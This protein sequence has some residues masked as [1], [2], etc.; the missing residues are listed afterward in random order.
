MHPTA[1][2]RL[3]STRAELNY[4]RIPCVDGLRGLAI[5]SVLYSHGSFSRGMPHFQWWPF[6]GSPGVSVFFILTGF[7]VTTLLLD[8]REKTGQI[9]IGKFLVRRAYRIWPALYGFLLSLLLLRHLGWASF[10]DRAWIAAATHWFNFYR[11]PNS[12][13]LSHMWSLSLQECFYLIWPPLLWRLRPRQALMFSLAL[14]LGWPLVRLLLD[15]ELAP[16]PAHL[17]LD[18]NGLNT[19]FYGVI[20]A[21]LMRDRAW[22]PWLKKLSAT[23]WGLVLPLAVLYALYSLH[24]IWPREW[25]VVLAPGRNLSVLIILWWCISNEKH[26]VGRLLQSRLLVFLGSISFSLYLWQQLFLGHNRGWV[27]DFPQNLGFALAAGTVSYWLLERPLRSLRARMRPLY[28]ARAAKPQP[29]HPPVNSGSGS[30]EAAEVLP[31][32]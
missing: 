22:L 32:S 9:R 19:I 4:P 25:A 12:W 16:W 7:L 26:Q 15:G 24:P 21:L 8:E 20:L 14:V 2:D 30:S 29:T 6:D 27:C 23:L 10:A 5:L 1:A 3:G 13:P 11:G 18:N 17:A 28:S 31:T